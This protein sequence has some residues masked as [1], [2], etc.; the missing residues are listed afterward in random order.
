MSR[1][2]RRENRTQNSQQARNGREAKV[3][4]ANLTKNTENEK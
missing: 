4:S 2:K 3:L 1:S